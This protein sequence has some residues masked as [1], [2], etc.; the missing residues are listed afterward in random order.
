MPQPQTAIPP[1]LLELSQRLEQWRSE[2]PRRSR[3]PES[4]WTAAVEMAQRHGLQ[5]TTKALRLD[6]T[7]LKNVCLR[8]CNLADR[9]RRTFWNYWCRLRQL[10]QSAWWS[11]NRRAGAC[12]W[13]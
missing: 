2:Q 5:R 6:Y 1:D 8:Y 13:Q 12:A 4:I 9:R 7:G 3:L 11:G 10:R